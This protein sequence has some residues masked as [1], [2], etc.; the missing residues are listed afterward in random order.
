MRKIKWI[1]R[2]KGRIIRMG[3]IRNIWKQQEI[4]ENRRQI[5]RKGEGN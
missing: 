1:L 3:K 5:R 2:N 4:K